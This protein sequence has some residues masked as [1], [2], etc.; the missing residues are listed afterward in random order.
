MVRLDLI[1]PAKTP[2]RK[3]NMAGSKKF[4]MACF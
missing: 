3:N 1:K 4:S 2:K